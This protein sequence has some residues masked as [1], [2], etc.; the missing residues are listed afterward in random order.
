MLKLNPITPIGLSTKDVESFTSLVVRASA[1]HMVSTSTLLRF[2]FETAALDT[3]C[4]PS[5]GGIR[6]ADLVRPNPTNEALLEAF[7]VCSNVSKEDL[8]RM[9]FFGL[10]RSVHRCSK[11]FAKSIRWCPAC[12]SE[13]NKKQSTPY[14]KLSWSLL[15]HSHCET[16]RTALIEA[17]PHCGR[18]QNST[19]A[20]NHLSV[21][22]HCKNPLYN[23]QTLIA[24]SQPPYSS[25]LLSL[26]YA[27]AS[28][29]VN[30]FPEGG[31]AKS[32]NEIYDAHWHSD[33]ERE[34]WDRIPRD[35][36]LTYL[37]S[38]PITLLIARRLA[39]QLDIPLVDILLGHGLH[40]TRSITHDWPN[41]SEL[42]FKAQRR[43]LSSLEL[44]RIK[45]SLKR[46]LEAGHAGEE[47]LSLAAIAKALG[48]STGGLE[49]HFPNLCDQLIALRTEQQAAKRIEQFK[50]AHHQAFKVIAENP[51]MGRKK[52]VRKLRRQHRLPVHILRKAIQIERATTN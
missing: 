2:C 20:N 15:G 47:A 29:P 13:W 40:T 39:T 21:C 44:I 45:T 16:H 23:E 9:T 36:C 22:N 37:E 24:E 32:L 14:L 6:S 50:L 51:N 52:L 46:Q 49:Y 34:L 41:D 4:S 35:D 1:R 30:D 12:F 27:T 31:A 11:T 7:Y 33:L 3:E 43:T 19:K 42:L 18:D 48:C 38:K 8:G 25:D 17:C 10:G 5:Y 26:V 28:L